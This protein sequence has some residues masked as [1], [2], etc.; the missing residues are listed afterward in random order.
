[1]QTSHEDYISKFFD[2]QFKDNTEVDDLDEN[3]DQDSFWFLVLPANQIHN[4]IFDIKKQTKHIQTTD[5]LNFPIIQKIIKM[6]KKEDDFWIN[7]HKIH[8]SNDSIDIKK[9]QERISDKIKLKIIQEI[10]LKKSSRSLI[11]EKLFISYLSVCRVIK[12]YGSD[13]K[14]FNK[15]F[16]S[17]F[18][19]IDKCSVIKTRIQEFISN[20][21]G[22]FWSTDIQKFVQVTTGLDMS[23]RDIINYMKEQLNFSFKKV[24]SRVI[25]EDQQRVYLFKII[26]CF[27][28]ANLLKRNL[29]IVN[30]DEVLF[31]NS[32]KTNYS[33][34][35]KGS[36]TIV[37]NI[38]FK[39][40][41]SLAQLLQR[42]AS[43]SLDFTPTTIQIILLI[44]FS[45]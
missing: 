31:S 41:Q 10:Y 14:V 12:E 43:S 15:M 26:Y 6:K 3:K 4:R 16:E 5:L 2:T 8:D 29:V 30:I 33:W 18:A 38:S 44:T 35:L 24:L 28:F 21:Q 20:E 1:M 13:F 40:S 32:I 36:S 22:W 45:I 9:P 17:R 23:R 25:I 37:H 27:E 19:K 34:G 7:D 39:G 11:S 42:V